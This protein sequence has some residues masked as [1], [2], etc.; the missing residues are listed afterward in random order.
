MLKIIKLHNLSNP[1]DNQDVSTKFYVDNKY[2]N[3]IETTQEMVI[4]PPGYLG[5]PQFE[6]IFNIYDDVNMNNKNIK[7]VSN[8]FDPNDAVNK[9]QLDNIIIENYN[10]NNNSISTSKL[11]GVLSNNDGLS[12]LNN[13]GQFVSVSGGS[14]FNNEFTADVNAQNLKL[15]I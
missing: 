15:L 13:K 9:S 11:S 12:Y 10:I 2:L 7:N 1:I 14:G 5:A 8:G 6:K 4:Q 3:S